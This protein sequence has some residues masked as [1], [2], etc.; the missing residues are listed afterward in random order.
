MAPARHLRALF[1]NVVMSRLRCS[2]IPMRPVVADVRAR[3]C[4]R[5]DII[6][7]DDTASLQR[8][9]GLA[10]WSGAIGKAA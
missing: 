8:A 5:V 6:I 3:C 7:G 1:G 2:T 9:P 10:R 4:Q